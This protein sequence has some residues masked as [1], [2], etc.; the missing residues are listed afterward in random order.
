[1]KL[2]LSLVLSQVESQLVPDISATS[3][4][5]REFFLEY[6]RN[7]VTTP[8][9]NSQTVINECMTSLEPYHIDT[10]F[11]KTNE[12]YQVLLHVVHQFSIEP[13]EVLDLNQDIADSGFQ[14]ELLQALETCQKGQFHLDT[15]EF[16][17][18][19]RASLYANTVRGDVATLLFAFGMSFS[20]TEQMT[21]AAWERRW[22][23]F[24]RRYT[25]SG[26]FSIQ[27]EDSQYISGLIQTLARTGMNVEGVVDDYQN[28][29]QNAYSTDP[30]LAAI[31]DQSAYKGMTV[32]FIIA[33]TMAAYPSFG[34]MHLLSTNPI[35]RSE[36]TTLLRYL[37]LIEGDVYAEC[38]LQHLRRIT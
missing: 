29:I 16:L 30:V 8:E 35:L 28:V 5:I 12:S 19:V 33:T 22:D 36:V 4:L 14:N 9:G 38:N 32:P 7:E 25:T 18:T 20:R 21:E 11:F 24:T 31:M 15:V 26:L 13:F 37:E 1:M 10:G 2:Q 17:L 6:L 27:R 23:P 34:W 3:F